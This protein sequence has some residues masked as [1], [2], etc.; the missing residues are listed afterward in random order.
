MMHFALV[1]FFCYRPPGPYL[2]E[3]ILTSHQDDIWFFLVPP[4]LLPLLLTRDSRFFFWF[5][6]TTFRTSY[7]FLTQI[8]PF[9]SKAS[10]FLFRCRPLYALPFPLFC[11]LGTSCLLSSLSSSLFTTPL[12]VDLFLP[13]SLLRFALPRSE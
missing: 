9:M 6:A 5:A 13:Q 12:A 2:P 1:C 4:P 10:C 11:P 8:F 7:P 3:P